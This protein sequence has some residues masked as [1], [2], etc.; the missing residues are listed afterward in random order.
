[1]RAIA[2]AIV[3]I[4]L[5]RVKLLISACIVLNRCSAACWA[6]TSRSARRRWRSATMVP[7]T[8][9]T[10]AENAQISPRTATIVNLTANMLANE[11]SA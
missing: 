9:R 2:D 3:P 4:A 6:V 10:M 5:S 1:M 11:A 8:L 7:V